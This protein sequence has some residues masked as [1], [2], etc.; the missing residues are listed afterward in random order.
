MSFN[1]GIF[2][3]RKNLRKS[4]PLR[5][6]ILLAPNYL[7]SFIFCP[8][9]I[10]TGCSIYVELLTALHASWF[11]LLM[12]FPLFH[13]L[14]LAYN[15]PLSLTYFLL[16][17]NCQY[18]LILVQF[19]YQLTQKSSLIFLLL[20]IPLSPVLSTLFKPLKSPMFISAIIFDSLCND[21]SISPLALTSLSRG[22]VFFHL[23]YTDA[24]LSTWHV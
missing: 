23:C 10:Q 11:F 14:P 15:L 19:R 21:V 24:K 3:L 4:S 6:L 20:P 8:S 2:E 17:S 13:S 22:I 12:L 16:T 18:Q 7:S 9:H 5:S 1:L